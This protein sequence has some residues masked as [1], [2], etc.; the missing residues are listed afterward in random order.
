MRGRSAVH[1]P[2]THTLSLSLS[3]T[4]SLAPEVTET[5]ATEVPETD[6]TLTRSEFRARWSE[7]FQQSFA[8]QVR[9]RGVAVGAWGLAL[10]VRIASYCAEAIEGGLA[11]GQPEGKGES[12]GC[13][14]DPGAMG[15]E[16]ELVRAG[17]S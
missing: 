5:L 6:S 7:F 1:T 14:V 11:E 17:I 9:F 3:L 15:S 8:G 10:G 13:I 4:L 16:E 12:D 2:H